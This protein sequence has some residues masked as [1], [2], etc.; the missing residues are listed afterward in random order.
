MSRSIQLF[1]KRL[2]DVGVCLV[3]LVLGSPLLAVCAV[4]VKLSS[5]GPVFFVQTRV[6]R[7]EKPYRMIKFRTMTGAP[8][9]QSMKWSAREEARITGAGHFLRDYGI[10]ELPQLINIIKG[11]MS[12]IGPRS[13]L[14][15]QVKMF[16]A[17]YKKM[18][19]MR[20]GVLSLAVI[21]GRRSVPI[22][23]RYELHVQYVETWSLA[24]DLKILWRSLFVVLRRES[25][26]DRL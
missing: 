20:P 16:P 19:A 3:L 9:P 17:R 26:R 1:I 12:I 13:P 22:E 23:K 2:I 7:N 21:A 14:P 18:F 6:G 4:V 24:L 10:D 5:P 8:D 15:Q 11:D 25:A